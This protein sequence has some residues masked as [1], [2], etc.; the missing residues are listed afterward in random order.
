M[1]IR[2]KCSRLLVSG[3]L[4][5]LMRCRFVICH[6]GC[7]FVALGT[8]RGEAASSSVLEGASGIGNLCW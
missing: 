2:P 5:G 6:P 1:H 4:G 8:S 7:C 3:T